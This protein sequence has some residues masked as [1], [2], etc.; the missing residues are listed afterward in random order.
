MENKQ[1]SEE[2]ETEVMTIFWINI[3]TTSFVIVCINDKSRQLSQHDLIMI[4]A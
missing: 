3:N 4:G 1:K 2:A